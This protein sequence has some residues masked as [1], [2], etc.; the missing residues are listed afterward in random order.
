MRPQHPPATRLSKQTP[1]L[2]WPLSTTAHSVRSSVA[3]SPSHPVPVRIPSRKPKP[4]PYRTRACLTRQQQQP[5]TF[6]F[7][8]IPLNAA[9][10]QKGKGPSPSSQGA[11]TQRLRTDMIHTILPWPPSWRFTVWTYVGM[12]SVHRYYV[13]KDTTDSPLPW[14]RNNAPG[15]FCP[16][17]HERLCGLGDWGRN[18]FSTQLCKACCAEYSTSV[19]PALQ[20]VRG[21]S[22]T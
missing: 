11:A 14:Q 20:R 1:P 4:L 15:A 16:V 3:T 8:H 18:T 22:E 5:G 13:K 6:L 21:V 17:C 12:P 10:S 2:A 9:S 7:S 19:S